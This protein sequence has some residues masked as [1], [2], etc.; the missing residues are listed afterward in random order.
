[1]ATLRG[2]GSQ[3]QGGTKR[4]NKQ[5]LNEGIRGLSA[6]NDQSNRIRSQFNKVHTSG[7]E[8]VKTAHERGTHGRY[9]E[10]ISMAAARYSL[11][12]SG[13][14]FL[15]V[16]AVCINQNDLLEKG[17]QVQ[18]MR[19][20]YSEAK[21]VISWINPSNNDNTELALRTLREIVPRLGDSKDFQR[22]RNCPKLCK[23]EENSNL[24]YGN[25]YWNSVFDLQTSD[26]FQRI[27]IVQEL[28]L[29][30]TNTSFFVSGGEFLP[31]MYLYDYFMWA[32]R[33]WKL[34]PNPT[35]PNFIDDHV[36][37]W[38]N[39]LPLDLSHLGDHLLRP[40]MTA[41]SELDESCGLLTL[42]S[43]RL[44]L[45]AF[46]R[47]CQRCHCSD[48][49]DKVFGLLG[50]FPMDIIPDYDRQV[51]DIFT[52]WATSSYWNVP[53]EMLLRLS[54]VGARPKSKAYR[55]FPSWVPDLGLLRDRSFALAS[56]DSY[57]ERSS[58]LPTRFVP[59]VSRDSECWR[60]LC[61]WCF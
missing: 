27:W 56:K 11:V 3:S 43:W 39:S 48:P 7:Q 45:N 42:D 52:D 35:P 6:N 19:D 34:L 38:M 49:R 22:M 16:D 51:E 32:Y 28:F 41:I 59:A 61:P 2:I 47:M 18:I 26:Y 44:K 36:W 20:V 13:N 21:F 1:M 5:D 55:N 58:R 10:A 15:W 31:L 54:G 23:Y 57:L 17:H 60:M 33:A 8:A 37:T 14:I 30:R 4:T 50:V 53:V 9:L 25:K 12:G 29:C 40:M 46:I 24:L